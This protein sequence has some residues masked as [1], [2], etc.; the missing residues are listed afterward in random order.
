MTRTRQDN[1]LQTCESEYLQRD[2]TLFPA[3]PRQLTPKLKVQR[4]MPQRQLKM[5]GPWCFLDHFGPVAPADYRQFDVPPHPHIGL[6]TITWLFSGQLLHKDS[7]GYE[8]SLRRGELNLMT[9]GSGIS[10]AEIAD[11]Q[12]RDPLHGLQLWAALPPAHEQTKPRFDHYQQVPQFS[13][14]NCLATL[15]SGVYAGKKST[16]ESPAVSFHPGVAMILQSPLST[17]ISLNLETEF[18]YGIYVCEGRIDIEGQTVRKHVLIN[19]G[20]NRSHLELEMGAD[21]TLIM[22]GGEAFDQ[23]IKMWWNFV[24]SNADRIQHAQQQWNAGDSRFG[25]VKGYQGDR[26]MAPEMPI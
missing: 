22:L 25:E 19:L 3:S 10:H 1:E 7:L 17:V 9:A 21:T 18:E 13:I 12:L 4:V 5:I 14:G 15:I 23:P 2:A 6:Q 20:S 16:H 8:Q 11:E 24:S 26:L